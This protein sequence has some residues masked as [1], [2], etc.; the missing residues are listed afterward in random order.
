MTTIENRLSDNTE[1]DARKWLQQYG[2]YLFRYARLHLADVNAAEDLVQETFL[3]ALRARE[4]F[5][6]KSSIKTWLTSILKNKIIDHLRMA[7]RQVQLDEVNP[8]QQGAENVFD[9]RGHWKINPVVWAANPLEIAERKEFWT[10]LRHCLKT[11][12]DIQRQAFV[13]REMDD[14][15]NEEICRL[16]G[17]TSS[18]YWV[19]L[20]RGRSRLRRCLEVKWFEPV[21]CP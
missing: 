11:M 12:P 8:G 9:A 15:E 5:S 19:I 18:N 13:L 16:L 3:S 14:I 4:S 1:L 2:D 10:M 21:A 7:G 6:G 20:H 17:V